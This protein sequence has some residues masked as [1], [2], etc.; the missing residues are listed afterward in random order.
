MQLEIRGKPFVFPTHVG[1]FL[2]LRD[3]IKAMN[4]LPHTRGGVS[5]VLVAA[6]EV[7]ESSPHTWGCF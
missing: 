6:T 7:V 5:A 3:T 4:G 2:E 1:V